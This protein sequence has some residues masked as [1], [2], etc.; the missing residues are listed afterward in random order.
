VEHVIARI[1]E[2]RW[3]AEYRADP[4][5]IGIVGHSFGGF[6]GASVTLKDQ[7]ISCYA[8]LAS[9]DQVV[10]GRALRRAS[11]ERRDQATKNIES[12]MVS[13][14]GREWQRI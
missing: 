13:S 10:E 4:A 7:G 9:S 2:P 12:Q 1:R 8:H 5:K 14:G 3:A 11:A 6:V